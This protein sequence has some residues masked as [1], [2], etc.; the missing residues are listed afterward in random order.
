[1]AMPWEMDWGGGDQVPQASPYRDAIAGIESAG[2]GDYSALGPRTRTGDRAYGRYQVMGANVGPWTEKHLGRRMSPEEFLADQDAQDRVFDGEFGSYVQKYGPAGAARAWFAGEGGM[3]DLGRRDGLGTSVA[4]YEQKFVGNMGQPAQPQAVQASA[5]GPMPWEMDWGSEA[6]T[7]AP[8]LQEPATRGVTIAPKG[9]D[10][11]QANAQEVEEGA[12]FRRG[13][14]LPIGRN[15]ETGEAGFAVPGLLQGAVEATKLPGDVY[16]GR[17][18]VNSPEGQQQALELAGLIAGVAPGARAVAPRI[19]APAAKLPSAVRSRIPA[20]ATEELKVMAQEA[21]K[22]ADEAG[23]TVAA[24][25][26]KRM[27]VGSAW[28]AKRAGIDPDLHPKAT[29]V[30]KRL[31]DQGNSGQP[32][33]L[34]EMDTL[35][36]VVK[37]AASSPDAGERRIAQILIGRLDEYMGGLTTK[38]VISGDAKAAVNSVR[39]ARS[40]W[41]RLRKAEVIDEL[42]EKAHNAVGANYSSAGLET[43][44]RQ[45]FRA[46]ADNK[47]KMRMFSKEEQGAIRRVVRGGPIE[48]VVRM[49]GK[50]APRGV[51]SGGFNIGVGA[52][53]GPAMGVASTI[54]GEVARRKASAMTQRNAE[55]VSEMVRRGGQ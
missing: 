9:G 53:M 48:N 4:K 2:S 35:R 54:A 1:M 51:I 25:S 6:E 13:S 42:F 20:P 11:R 46:L 12:T 34:R 55:R 45:K 19:A 8:E 21:Y 44:L 10:P 38:D 30:L 32:M 16:A 18:D 29:A 26:L 37:D 15:M 24:P 22:R 23:L 36:Q 28:A 27:A 41:S 50:M 31:I 7:A 40:L 47:Q 49:I 52:T 33:T 14:I 39:E 3:N 5:A 17:V 43:A